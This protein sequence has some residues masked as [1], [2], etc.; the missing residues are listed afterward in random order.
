MSGG[1]RPWT[2]EEDDLMREVY[3]VT[4]A[5]ELA[6]MFGRTAGAVRSRARK[7]GVQGPPHK[8]VHGTLTRYRRGCR[9]AACLAAGRKRERGLRAEQK[10]KKDGPP[11]HSYSGYVNYGCRCDVCREATREYL[12][13]VKLRN[14]D[15]FPPFIDTSWT[16]RA[17]CAGMD[18]NIFFLEH[19]DSAATARSICAS[20]PVKD[21]C[22]ELGLWQPNDAFGI[23][24]GT[25]PRERIEIR[26]ERRERGAA[27]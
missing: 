14:G 23:F 4:S 2:D 21:E 27:A 26:K 18:P 5:I 13:Q 16:E 20:C 9:C 22:L 3:G 17:A 24:G 15:R 8:K 12:R 10:K 19:G 25:T 6:T 1:S 7:L 11:T